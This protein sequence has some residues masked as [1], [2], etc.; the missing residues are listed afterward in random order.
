MSAMDLHYERVVRSY[1]AISALFKAHENG[2][3]V[4]LPEVVLSFHYLLYFG[5]SPSRMAAG[6][7]S[8][9]DSLELDNPSAVGELVYH[10]LPKQA[11]NVETSQVHPIA[12]DRISW[13]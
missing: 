1:F 7:R 5:L 4:I 3:C 9:L 12:L 8:A 10:I 6:S 13:I 2:K 11:K